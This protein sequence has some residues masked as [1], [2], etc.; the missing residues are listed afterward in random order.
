MAVREPEKYQTYIIP[1]NFIDESRVINGMF[2]TRNFVEACL[3]S[4]VGLVIGLSIPFRATT[5]KITVL[6]AFM[7]PFF[8]LGIFG[9]NGDPVSIAVKN[10]LHWLRNR[11][12]VLYDEK[13]RVLTDTPLAKMMSRTDAREQLA[14]YLD[15]MKEQRLERQLQ[16]TFEEGKTFRFAEDRDYTRDY[17][18]L[19]EMKPAEEDDYILEIFE[20]DDETQPVPE[21]DS[22]KTPFD[23]NKINDTKNS[24][25][26]LNNCRSDFFN[27]SLEE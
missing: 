19:D 14:A 12:I 11:D 17:I 9:I 27:N 1:D 22:T 25:V 3:Y 7:A 4:V 8:M 13:P 21:L 20:P 23:L 2:R 5:T 18:N 10:V 16:E 6:V 24:V 26:F 15:H